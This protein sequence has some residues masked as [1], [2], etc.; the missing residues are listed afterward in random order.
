M[1]KS[2]AKQPPIQGMSI[3]EQIKYMNTEIDWYQGK[4]DND[5]PDWS[6]EFYLSKAILNSLLELQRIKDEMPKL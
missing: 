6:R 2:E 5:R 1:S 4:V 3:Q